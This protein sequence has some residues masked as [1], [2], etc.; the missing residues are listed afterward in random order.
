MA[1]LGEIVAFGG[2]SGAPITGVCD[3][4]REESILCSSTNGIV[5][6]DVRV[7]G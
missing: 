5:V 6:Y 3:A 1:Q 4:H 7:N 2:G